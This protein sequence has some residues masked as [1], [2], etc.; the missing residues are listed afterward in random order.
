MRDTQEVSAITVVSPCGPVQPHLQACPH[1]ALL[2]LGSQVVCVHQLLCGA[3]RK[4]LVNRLLGW[5]D[6]WMGEMGIGIL[7]LI[8][9]SNVELIQALDT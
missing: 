8:M 9:V 1:Q 4:G 5:M 2:R 6:G 7:D 3:E